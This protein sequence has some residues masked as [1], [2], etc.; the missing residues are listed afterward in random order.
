MS[1]VLG[2]RE[3]GRDDVAR[4]GGKGANLGELIKA[5]FDV[6][7]GFVLTTEYGIPAI[8]GTDEGPSFSATASW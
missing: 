1:T 5:G 8:M 4:A 7:D 2:L 6:P 3:L